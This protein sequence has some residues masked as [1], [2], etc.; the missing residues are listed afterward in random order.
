MGWLKINTGIQGDQHSENG[1]NFYISKTMTITILFP[2]IK[3]NIF[4]RI[5]PLEAWWEGGKWLLKE[6]KIKPWTFGHRRHSIILVFV[7]RHHLSRLKNHM[8][9]IYCFYFNGTK[10]GLQWK[11]M[12]K[13]PFDK[14]DVSQ[15]SHILYNVKAVL[16]ERSNV[17]WIDL[18]VCNLFEPADYSMQNIGIGK[19]ADKW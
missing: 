15:V 4:F 3:N 8:V 19:K 6:K 16:S 13:G 18:A 11:Q 12:D 2:N 10:I 1:V 9:I 17:I 5:Q 14:E 7:F